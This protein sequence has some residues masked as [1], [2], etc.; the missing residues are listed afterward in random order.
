MSNI[1]YARI[2][3]KDYPDT[4][5]PI[6]A[7]NLN[8]MDK[9]I[10]DVVAN[11]NANGNTFDFAY[12]NT[13]QRYGYNIG[14]TFNPFKTAHTGTY[15]PTSRSASL[16]M[17]EDHTYRYVNTNSVPNSN[18]STFNATTNGTHDMG[19]TNNYRYVT[20][21]VTKSVRLVIGCVG[22]IAGVA[23]TTATVKWWGT[24]SVKV[25]IN[26]TLTA[27]Y[28]VTSGTSQADGR[29]VANSDTPTSA[30]SSDN[31]Y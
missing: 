13:S 21:N 6:N 20:V 7:T 15:T 12:D 22:H 9:A 1:N 27:S 31:T 18:S 19:A 29:S 4:D 17:G 25:Y 14:G 2:N 3:W 23:G 5:T 8:K 28:T 24:A 16:D 11:M 26:G 10:S 30:G